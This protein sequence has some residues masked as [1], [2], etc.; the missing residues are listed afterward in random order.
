M[1]IYNRYNYSLAGTAITDEI[2]NVTGTGTNT[3]GASNRSRGVYETG[4]EVWTGAGKTGTQLVLNTDY[5]FQNQDTDYTA[6]TGATVYSGWSLI[7]TATY[8]GVDLYFNYTI[9][10]SYIDAEDINKITID[11]QTVSTSTTISTDVNATQHIYLATTGASDKTITLD[12]AAD[13]QDEMFTFKK[14]DSGAGAL[15]IDGEGAETIDGQ[16]TIK[17]YKQ[18]TSVSIISDGTSWYIIDVI[19]NEFEESGFTNNTDWTDFNTTFNHGLNADLDQIEVDIYLSSDGTAANSFKIDNIMFT[20]T[21]NNLSYGFQV[22]Y[23]DV[24][25]VDIQTGEDGARYL[26][27]NGASTPLGSSTSFYYNI[28]ARRR[29]VGY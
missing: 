24:D 19:N 4:I 16:A 23:N 2:Y 15:I 18:N 26:G 1:S 14:V 28:V 11:V 22:E 10:G 20:S 3:F 5:Q 27:V 12:A 9:V 6:K 8:N 7:N 21:T 17:I 29:R 25:N 13:R